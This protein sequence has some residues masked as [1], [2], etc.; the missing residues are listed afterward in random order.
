MGLNY[1]FD[2]IR[3]GSPVRTGRR[4]RGRFTLIEARL[5]GAGL[6][7]TIYDVIVEIENERKPALSAVWMTIV[8]FDPKDRR[9][10]F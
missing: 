3:F 1:G 7:M 9:E 4:I 6:M 8:Q 2:K 10:N 5:R